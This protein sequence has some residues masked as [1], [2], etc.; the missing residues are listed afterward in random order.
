[1]T[2]GW[3]IDGT[4]AKSLRSRF[5]IGS[6]CFEVLPTYSMHISEAMYLSQPQKPRPHLKYHTQPAAEDAVQEQVGDV[7]C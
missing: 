2:L 6:V 5:V 1:M 3:L 7:T 4:M